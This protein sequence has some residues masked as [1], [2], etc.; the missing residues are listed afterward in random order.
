MKF[1]RPEVTD[2]QIAI[3]RTQVPS[4]DPILIIDSLEADHI[5]FGIEE[6]FDGEVLVLDL[7]LALLVLRSTVGLYFLVHW[8]VHEGLRINLKLILLKVFDI[9]AHFETLN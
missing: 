7:D 5:F 9:E 2:E 6:D 4:V 3:Q 1:V 8:L